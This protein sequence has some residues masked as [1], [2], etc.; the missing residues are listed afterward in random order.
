MSRWVNE[1]AEGAGR[2]GKGNEVLKC[3]RQKYRAKPG[4]VAR[5]LWP[6][7]RGEMR[8]RN[9]KIGLTGGKMFELGWRLWRE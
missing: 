2:E 1:A 9:A 4:L 3:K 5:D 7:K 8:G 6:V